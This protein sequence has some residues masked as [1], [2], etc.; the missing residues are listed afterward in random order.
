MLLSHILRRLSILL[1]LAYILQILYLA[2]LLA[3]LLLAIVMVD[4][5]MRMLALMRLSDI[6]TLLAG[7]DDIHKLFDLVQGPSLHLILVNLRQV[8]QHKIDILHLLLDDLVHIILEGQRSGPISIMKYFKPS[9]GDDLP[10][11]NR[12]YKWLMWYSDRNS[13]LFMFRT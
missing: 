12:A 11:N 10:I 5:A 7:L 13:S 3:T 4:M 1:T 9:H 8:I 6:D 2:L